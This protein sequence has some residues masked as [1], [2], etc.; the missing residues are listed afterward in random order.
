MHAFAIPAESGS[1]TY[2]LKEEGQYSTAGWDTVL[3][4]EMD[5]VAGGTACVVPLKF[6]VDKTCSLNFKQNLYVHNA[7]V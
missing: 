6:K 5:K 7:L 2:S 3:G 1:V 4:H